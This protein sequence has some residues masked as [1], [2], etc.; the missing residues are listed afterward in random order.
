MANA[1]HPNSAADGTG[2]AKHAKA[3]EAFDANANSADCSRV[4]HRAAHNI[5]PAAPPR[6]ATPVIARGTG[7]RGPS[8]ETTSATKLS[9]IEAEIP[10]IITRVGP[11]M[12]RACR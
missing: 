4:G 6:K 2:C 7:P 10:A 5:V 8:E 9:A 11:P 1:T 12:P 3:I